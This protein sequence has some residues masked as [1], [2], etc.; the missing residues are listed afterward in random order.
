MLNIS[1]S[2]VYCSDL[3]TNP[4]DEE[5]ASDNME[6]QYNAC[7]TLA[8]LLSDTDDKWT[9]TSHTKQQVKQTL[10]QVVQSWNIDSQRRINYRYLP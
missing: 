4:T 9:C 3:A 2:I 1:V 7:G 6:I 5:I 8:H 10:Y